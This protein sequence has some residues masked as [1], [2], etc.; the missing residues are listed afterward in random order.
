M[1]DKIG[2]GSTK[3]E[4]VFSEMWDTRR[5]ILEGFT[6]VGKEMIG[7]ADEEVESVAAE[8]LAICH[9]CPFLSENKKRCDSCGC[10]LA[11]KTRSMESECPEEKW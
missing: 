6:N 2:V 7:M 5:N 4:L 3:F 11:A 10:I 8:R 9:R 1:S